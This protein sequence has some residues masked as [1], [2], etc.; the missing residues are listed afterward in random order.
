MNSTPSHRTA[1]ARARR[2]ALLLLITA[3][4][5]GQ[6]LDPA[7]QAWSQGRPAE[8]IPDLAVAATPS[9]WARLHD[10]G[11]ALAAVSDH[12]N[13]AA[14][15]VAAV[16]AAPSRPEPRVALGWAL[17]E[18]D[19]I[20]GPTSSAIAPLVWLSTSW[21]GLV[22]WAVVGLALGGVV[23]WP[24]RRGPCAAVL[25]LGIIVL[26]PGVVVHELD[27]AE[28]SAWAATSRSTAL[29]DSTGTS[30]VSLPAATLVTRVDRPAWSGRVMVTTV[31]GTTGW[32][33]ASDLEPDLAAW[34]GQPSAP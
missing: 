12:G 27:R 4:I 28:V 13:A 5:A 3:G 8:A 21:L 30:I 20:A 10:L 32:V 6:D 15:L 19:R 9:N 31:N 17:G 14:V 34:T 29:V 26:V 7:Y 22:G 18:P 24:A 16:Q 11:L 23:L 33:I 25:L 1:T 2:W